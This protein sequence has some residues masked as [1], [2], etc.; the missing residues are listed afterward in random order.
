MRILLT[1]H[2]PFEG[3]AAGALVLRLAQGFIDRGHSVRLLTVDRERSETCSF[4]V[5]TVVCN[6]AGETADL[7]FDVPRFRSEGDRHLTFHDLSNRQL[8]DYRQALREALD[9]EIADFDPHIIHAQHIWLQGHL[10]LEGGVPYVLTAWGPELEDAAWELRYRRYAQET[11]ENAGQILA[12]TAEL[13]AAVHAL[14]GDLEGRVLVVPPDD[15]D[16]ALT[17]YQQVLQ[18]R[19]G[20]TL[21]P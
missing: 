12:A 16:L 4:P 9:A 1:N 15:C 14:F 13:A 6:S 7:R 8:S 2:F 3:S 19:F 11:A 18:S 5:R 20:D 21:R 10:V 17:A